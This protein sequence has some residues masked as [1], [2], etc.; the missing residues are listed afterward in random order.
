MSKIN[1]L[2]KSWLKRLLTGSVLLALLLA[3]AS[4]HTYQEVSK[5]QLE[6][7]L[8]RGK[9]RFVMRHTGAQYAT[10]AKIEEGLE[11]HMAEMFADQ[12]GVD[13][14]IIVAKNHADM[15]NILDRNKADIA[16][17]LARDIE[18]SKPLHY[19]APYKVTKEH[20][21]YRRG[22]NRPRRVQDLTNG[23]IAVSAE[24]SYAVRLAEYQLE[25]ANLEYMVDNSRDTFGLME[26]VINGELD[27]T[28]VNSHD[29]ELYRH[30]YPELQIGFQVANNQ[31]V[32]WALKPVT[33]YQTINAWANSIKNTGIA[34]ATFEKFQTNLL[35]DDSLSVL[36]DEFIV[37]L[38]K[39][40]EMAYLLDVYFSHLQKFNYVDTSTFILRIKSVLPEY[41]AIFREAA[42]NDLDWMLLAAIGY[43]ESHWKPNARSPTGVRGLMML[44]NAT[45]R[46]VGVTNRV[47]PVQS[48]HGGAKYFR[49]MHDRIPESVPEPDRTWM[50]LASYNIGYGHL[51]DVRR[52][53]Q[54]NGGDPNKWA[55]V[56]AWLPKKHQACWYSQTRHGFA[57]GREAVAYVE[58]IRRYY[59]IL[60]YIEDGDRHPLLAAV[61]PV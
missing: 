1:R 28:I 46:C 10:K 24:T 12:L 39:T 20:V 14:E 51:E 52:L 33:Q 44:T 41:E 8:E 58:N 32:S 16:I 18:L 31:A 55:D 2:R 5:S 7:V 25:H 11:Y 19:T 53:V 23:S 56:R 43:Q 22:E 47:D 45:S 40:G 54:R 59:D 9:V 50:A 42:D 35:V 29:L 27:Y 21:V 61:G 13:F 15:L 49:M 36:V 17:G 6:Q 4:V 34:P 30:F 60:R 26:L 57:R 38:E 3:V 48:I 37:A